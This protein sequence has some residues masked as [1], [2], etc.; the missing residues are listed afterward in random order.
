MKQSLYILI[1]MG[2]AETA[3]HALNLCSAPM[4]YFGAIVLA[5]TFMLAKLFD[6]IEK[7][8]ELD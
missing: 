6:A 1:G 2:L 7:V 5:A 4:M 3:H 8:A